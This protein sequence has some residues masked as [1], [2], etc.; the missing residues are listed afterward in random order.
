MLTAKRCP[1]LSHRHVACRVQR[2]HEYG[3]SSPL[4]RY[5]QNQTLRVL[6]CL[7]EMTQKILR[8]CLTKLVRTQN[9]WGT[10]IIVNASFIVQAKEVEQL[11]YKDLIRFNKLPFGTRS[12]SA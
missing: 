2:E 8:G 9:V 10:F 7:A 1:S 11:F 4:W 12:M 3:R 5:R 6:Q